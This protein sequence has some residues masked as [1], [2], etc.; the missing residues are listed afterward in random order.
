[1][2]GVK[3]WCLLWQGKGR[4]LQERE[5]SNDGHV[6]GR[7]ETRG[8]FGETLRFESRGSWLRGVMESVSMRMIKQKD[9]YELREN[10][11][12]TPPLVPKLYLA[13]RQP[14]DLMKLS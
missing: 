14:K 11:R 10:Q 12:L 3:K 6:S 1:M 4:G 9:W 8:R 13:A 2:D 5:S 7:A